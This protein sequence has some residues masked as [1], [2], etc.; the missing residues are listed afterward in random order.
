MLFTPSINKKVIQIIHSLMH[1]EFLDI[2]V[3]IRFTHIIHIKPVENPH[4][5]A[6]LEVIYTKENKKYPHFCGYCC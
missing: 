6:Q 2:L 5:C 1:I 3:F 4:F